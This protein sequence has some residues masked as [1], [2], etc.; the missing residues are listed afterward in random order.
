MQQNSKYRNLFWPASG[1]VLSL[2]PQKAISY[3][4]TSPVSSDCGI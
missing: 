2:A 3:H 1:S 4:L